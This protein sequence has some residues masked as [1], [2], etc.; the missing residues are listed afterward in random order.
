MD[1]IVDRA[2]EYN[3][4]TN[5]ECYNSTC[6][7]IYNT[8]RT[9]RRTIYM[10]IDKIILEETN[11]ELRGWNLQCTPLSLPIGRYVPLIIKLDAVE[12]YLRKILNLKSTDELY[13]EKQN[14][15]IVLHY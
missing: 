12:K 2:K 5:S 13:V 7:I 11:A 4:F 10:D 1:I 9:Y 6:I 14:L 8:D 15:I 3:R